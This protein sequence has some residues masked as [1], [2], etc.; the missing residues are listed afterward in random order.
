M[1]IPIGWAPNAH[2]HLFKHLFSL[3]L[4][5][6]IRAVGYLSGYLSGRLNKSYEISLSLAVLRNCVNGFLWI[7]DSKTHYFIV[8]PILSVSAR[9]RRVYTNTCNNDWGQNE[10]LL[11]GMTN[12]QTA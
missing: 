2:N 8:K 9:P 11:M 10:R 4:K 7:I 3:P 12:P 1:D 5:Y 6:I